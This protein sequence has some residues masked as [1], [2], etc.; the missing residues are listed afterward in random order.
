MVNEI[1][2]P[3]TPSSFHGRV[4]LPALARTRWQ[5]VGAGGVICLRTMADHSM[6]NHC[7]GTDGTH[8]R[9]L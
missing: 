1:I 3:F 7:L 8:H 5:E 9:L 6:T 2:E 4:A